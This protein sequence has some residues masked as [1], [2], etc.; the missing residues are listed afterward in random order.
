MARG[1]EF[2]LQ[3][4]RAT[5]RHGP[6]CPRRSSS[7][8]RAVVVL[9][10]SRNG[11][12]REPGRGI[13]M[14]DSQCVVPGGVSAKREKLL[15]RGAAA[16]TRRRRAACG[17]ST[18][19][20]ANGIPSVMRSAHQERAPATATGLP[21]RVFDGVTTERGSR[22]AASFQTASPR[23]GRLHP[24]ASLWCVP[25]TLES[26]PRPGPT[27][28]RL[29]CSTLGSGE[30]RRRAPPGPVA[31]P[32][33]AEATRPTCSAPRNLE[34]GRWPMESA[35]ASTAPP[36]EPCSRLRGG[37]RW[38]PITRCE[39]RCAGASAC[40]LAAGRWPVPAHSFVGRMELRHPS[41]RL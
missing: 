28:A 36:R 19:C 10:A 24:S 5:S 17:N 13:A 9:L 8:R 26:L 12:P 21:R 23:P 27:T 14:S 15:L 29:D 4:S 3:I 31:V 18:E 33:L 20:R 11:R 30:H 34:L 7:S 39:A 32:S 6:R 22:C 37:R 16:W 25:P 35:S 40:T 1:R 2:H 38:L 41:I